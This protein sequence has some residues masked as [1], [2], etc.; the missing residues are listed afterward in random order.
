MLAQGVP[1]DMQQTYF[2]F[3]GVGDYAAQKVFRGAGGIGDTVGDQA[4]GAGFGQG[5]F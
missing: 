5:Q 1:R 4:A 3:V 2:G